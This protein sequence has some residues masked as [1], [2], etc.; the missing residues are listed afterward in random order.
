MCV[1]IYWVDDDWKIQKRIINFLHVP[2]RHSGENMSLILSSCLL[3]CFIEKKMFSLTLD[4]ASA[5]EV[6]LKEVILELNKRNPLICGGLFFH[7]RCANHILNLVAKDG[8]SVMKSY[9][10]N[11]RAFVLVVK[12]LEMCY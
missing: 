12:V 3:K 1:T 2:G 8:M 5:N 7:I 9:I 4:N 11:I 6:A 10:K